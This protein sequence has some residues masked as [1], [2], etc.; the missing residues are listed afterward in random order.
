MIQTNLNLAPRPVKYQ[1]N[2]VIDRLHIS[3]AIRFGFMHQHNSSRCDD[4]ALINM[5]ADNVLICR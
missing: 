2:D 3:S 5:F 1:F 4:A